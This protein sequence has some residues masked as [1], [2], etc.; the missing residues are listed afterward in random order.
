M[1]SIQCAIALYD[2]VSPVLRDMGFALDRFSGRM[3]RFGEEMESVVP[4]MEGVAL[5]GSALGELTGEAERA[6]GVLGA[7][8]SAGEEIAGVFSQDVFLPLTDGAALAT[9]RVEELFGEMGG[10]I[11]GTF[12][13]LDRGATVVAAQLPRHFAGPLG[14]VAGMFASMAASAMASMERVAGSARA[15]VGA[16]SAVSASAGVS[17][18]VIAPLQSG[19]GAVSLFGMPE[20]MVA[21]LPEPELRVFA[22]PDREALRLPEPEVYLRG[23]VGAQALPPVVSVTVHNENYITSE[24]DVEAVL[25]EM[26]LRLAEAVASSMEGVYA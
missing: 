8:L 7:V 3:I 9:G 2:G 20:Q 23:A 24:V 19:G 25:R 22:V 6:F 13:S 26:E 15:A 16:V 14:Q 11:E 17:G 21:S 5:F 18:S 1:A 10:E 4:E 12:R